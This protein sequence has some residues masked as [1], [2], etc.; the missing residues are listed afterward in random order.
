MTKITV[1]SINC[2]LSIE[3]SMSVPGLPYKHAAYTVGIGWKGREKGRDEL[4]RR[5]RE[6]KKQRK[7]SPVLVPSV[8]LA[9]VVSWGVQPGLDGGTFL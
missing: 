8:G 9:D 1:L 2:T 4:R 6:K 5:E 3:M 7:R